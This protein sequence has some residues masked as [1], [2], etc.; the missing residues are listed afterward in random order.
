VPIENPIAAT[1]VFKMCVA[2]V[3]RSY[4]VLALCSVRWMHRSLHCTVWALIQRF[5]Y[6]YSD[7]IT[8]ADML[9]EL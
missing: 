9:S 6:I 1:F 3:G 8:I 5:V 7:C 4:S 2:R